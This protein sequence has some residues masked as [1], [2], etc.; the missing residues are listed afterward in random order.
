MII[1]TVLVKNIR[2]FLNVCN[3]CKSDDDDTMTLTNL[4]CLVLDLDEY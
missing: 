1:T 3:F 4:N 2:L